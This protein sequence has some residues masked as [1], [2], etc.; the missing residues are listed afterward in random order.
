MNGFP[1]M[2]SNTKMKIKMKQVLSVAM[3]LAAFSLQAATK[4]ATTNAAPAASTNSKPADI[5]ANL[6]GDPV[7]AKAKGFEI[8]RSDM[9]TLITKFK[10]I[11]QSQGRPVPPQEALEKIVLNELITQKL[12]LAKATDADRTAATKTVNLQITNLLSQAGSQEALE[13]QFKLRGTTAGEYRNELMQLVTA[14][15]ALKREL[16]IKIG[17][18]DVK[19]YYTGHPTDFEEPEKIHV[20]HILFLTMDPTNG[21]QLAADKKDAKR[22]Q[23]EDVLKKA[24]GGDDFAK[25]A[26]Q[27]SE[28]P[29][30]KDNGGDLPLFDKE[31]DFAGGRMGPEFTGASFSLT[32]N[33]VSDIVTT[34]YG[35][36]IIKSYG[37]TPATKLALGDKIPGT[38]ITISDRLRDV[39]AQQKLATQA[40][41]FIEKLQKDANVQ[42]LDPA[43]KAAMDEANAAATNAIPLPSAK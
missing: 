13:K 3:V 40:P 25:L 18:A 42:I 37:K 29:G 19:E 24:R 28:D 30:S 27:Y 1:Q 15:E 32:N 26:K 5:M 20:H 38:E 23:A 34:E 21:E 35:F 6:F 43:L 11:L 41:A 33:Q 22:K 4:P 8:K 7:I 16:G 31:G 12:L 10:T 17:D 36:H 2:E 14:N 9:D 39:L